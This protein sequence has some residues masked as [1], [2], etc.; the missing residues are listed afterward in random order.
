MNRTLLAAAFAFASCAPTWAALASFETSDGYQSPHATR[1]WTYNPLWHFEGG[2]LGNNYVSQHGYGAGFAASTPFA[3]AVRND[4]PAGNFRFNYEFEA[5]DLAGNNPASLSGHI[6][7]VAFDLCVVVSDGNV[8]PDGTAG[9]TMAF[10]DSRSNPVLTL[11]ISDSN[12]LMYSDGATFQEYTGYTLNSHGWD[13]V[14]I[15]FDFVA[16]TYDLK[17]LPMTGNSLHSSHLWTPS[18]TLNVITGAAFTDAS[19]TSMSRLWWEVFT[20]PDTGGGWHKS[21]FDNFHNEVPEPST[22]ATVFGTMALIAWKRRGVY[23]C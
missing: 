11:G 21:F 19:A 4:N 13:R 10:G 1:V 9:I 7:K 3:L 2:A 20:D 5:S 22:L 15:E 6:F 16:K 8:T 18:Q 17:L 12:Y 23:R 14:V